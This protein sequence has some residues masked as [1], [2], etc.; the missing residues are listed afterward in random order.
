MLA[1]HGTRRALLPRGNGA[2]PNQVGFTM[3]EVL[4][5]RRRDRHGQRLLPHTV[6]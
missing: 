4:R 6:P 3:P 2:P 5:A 1:V